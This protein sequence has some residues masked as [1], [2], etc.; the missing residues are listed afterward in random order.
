M[1]AVPR[2]RT[3]RVV[4]KN[5]TMIPDEIM[6]RTD[7]THLAKCL[8]GYMCRKAR[9]GRWSGGTRLLARL[10][11][12]GH[13]QVARSIKELESHH[14]LQVLRGRSGQRPSYLIEKAAHIAT[15]P[16]TQSVAH[17]DGA[18]HI[19]TEAAHIA[20]R[21]RLRPSESKKK[22]PKPPWKGGFDSSLSRGDRKE[23]KTPAPGIKAEKDVNSM[24]P[25]EVYAETQKLKR[26]ILHGAVV[27]LFYPSGVLPRQRQR[28]K[29]LVNDLATLSATPAE[30]RR[31]KR[32]WG[33]IYRDAPCTLRSLV[34][35]WDVLYRAPYP[36]QIEED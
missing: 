11:G 14:L 26:E 25:A 13:Q 1:P 22:P 16:K 9:D 35:R 15:L 33:D 7:L 19:A 29:A 24:T 20:T 12:T 18:S 28:V 6:C 21:K 30:V 31:R 34:A 3:A 17:C 10:C 8:Y 32:R 5:F 27:A 4:A 2:S 23:E 36:G